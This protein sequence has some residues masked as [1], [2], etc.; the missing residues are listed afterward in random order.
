MAPRAFGTLLA[1][2][3]VLGW[4]RHLT[5]EHVRGTLDL[6]QDPR[7]YSEHGPW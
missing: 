4:H 1:V 5:W 3:Y 6:W 7:N 2:F